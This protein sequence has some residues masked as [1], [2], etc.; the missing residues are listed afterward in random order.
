[1]SGADVVKVVRFDRAALEALKQLTEEA[2]QE[3]IRRASERIY[4]YATTTGAVPVD[5]GRL[6]ASFD[7]AFTP[8]HMA[9]KWDP[10]DPRNQFHYAQHVDTTHRTHSN[11]SGDIAFAAKEILR[12]EL[13]R[14]LGA[15]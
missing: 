2:I 7:I 10:V 8:R 1:M 15:M 13:L 5:T 14:A 3:A 9:M 6:Q 12:E 4:D 11:F